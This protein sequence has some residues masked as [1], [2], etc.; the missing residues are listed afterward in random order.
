MYVYTDKYA[1][2]NQYLDEYACMWIHTI[3]S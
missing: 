1:W 3:I 2:K